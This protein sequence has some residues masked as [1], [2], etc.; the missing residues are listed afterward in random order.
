M[1]IK[2][3]IPQSIRNV[4]HKYQAFFANAKYGFP[5]SDL[6]IIGITGTD[7]KTTTAN[8]I[9]HI[10]KEGGYKV[11]LISTVSAKIGKKE[12]DTGFHVTT[13]DPWDIPKY[14]KMM[15]DKGIKWVILEVTSHALDQN[16]V[17]YINFDKAVFTNITNEH[18]DYHK[19]WKRLALTKAKLISLLKEGGE[20]IYKNDEKGATTIKNH[21]KKSP[22]VL[23]TNICN[24]D[25]VSDKKVS[26]EGLGFSYKI[27]REEFEVFIPI[28]GEYNIAN[29]QCAIKTCEDLVK[30]STIVE[31]LGNYKQ[32]KGRMQVIRRKKPCLVIIDFA[33]TPNAMK[34]A[35]GTIDNLK[36]DGT[37]FVVFGSAGL[38][39]IKKRFGMGR[40]ASKLADVVII[41]SEDPRT[42]SLKKIND[43]ILEGASIKKS[44]LIKRFPDRVVF[45]KSKVSTLKKY[46][47]NNKKSDKTSIFIFD[48]ETTNSREDAIELA[49]RSANSNDVVIITGKAHEKSLCFGKAE[50]PWSDY[51]AVK[52]ALSLRYKKKKKK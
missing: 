37:V 25:M 10:L 1:N 2:D 48:E 32:V 43:R 8:M 15:R 52:R 34:S 26:R 45:N 39:D 9:Y 19:T 7:G 33:H 36:E 31:A 42:E 51:D 11:G 49:I 5:S 14:L 46:I 30:G 50:Y 27:K 18:L 35:L 38:R 28:V 23:V 12:I 44:T 3:I 4:Y 21:I 20:V 47:H 22:N 6:N 40:I 17:A 24:D 16:R 41:T 13:P 29:A